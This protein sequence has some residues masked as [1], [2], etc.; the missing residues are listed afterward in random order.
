MQKNIMFVTKH[1]Q[2]IIDFLE[3]Q[4]LPSV[5]KIYIL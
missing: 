2:V 4:Y 3:I 5:F 1:V